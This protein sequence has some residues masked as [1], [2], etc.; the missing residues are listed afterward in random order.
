MNTPE[1]RHGD[2]RVDKNCTPH[3]ACRNIKNILIRPIR[4]AFGIMV[5]K[6][7]NRQKYKDAPENNSTRNGKFSFYTGMFL[8]LFLFRG[9]QRT[10]SI[11]Y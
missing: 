2:H 1:H 4:L 5:K 3:A 7:I 8:S 9:R 10:K 11:Q 6:S